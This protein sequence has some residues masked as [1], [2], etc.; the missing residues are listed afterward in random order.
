MSKNIIYVPIKF[1]I[2]MVTT[3]WFIS[4]PTNPEALLEIFYTILFLLRNK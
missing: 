1:G 3:L 2:V 4:D